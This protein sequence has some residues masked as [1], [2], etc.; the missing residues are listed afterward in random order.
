VRVLRSAWPRLPHAR[1]ER[2]G[3]T[4]RGRERRRERERERG[5]EGERERVF[6]ESYSEA[7]VEHTIIT[8]AR[9]RLRFRTAHEHG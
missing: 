6:R 3:E 2:G 5:R 1:E 4:Q 7:L 9:G 8:A